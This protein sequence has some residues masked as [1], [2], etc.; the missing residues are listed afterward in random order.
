LGSDEFLRVRVGIQ[1]D[2]NVADVKDFVLSRVGK[3]DR[4]LLDQTED[5]AVKAVE[6]LIAHGIE[7]AMAEFNGIDLRDA[8]GSR[9]GEAEK[10]N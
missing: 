5:I 2:R 6:T 3:G 4:V 10:E 7:R 8:A 1:P 9:G